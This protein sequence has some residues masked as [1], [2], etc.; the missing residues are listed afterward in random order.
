MEKVGSQHEA[1]QLGEGCP[2][3][4]SMRGLHGPVALVAACLLPSCLLAFC[5]PRP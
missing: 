1:A 5:L 2:H 3:G 4:T